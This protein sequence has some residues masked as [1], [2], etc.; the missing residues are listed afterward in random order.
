MFVGKLK[1][2]LEEVYSLLQT[3][4]TLSIVNF[5]VQAYPTLVSEF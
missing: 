3:S 4:W 2:Q 1:V 5:I